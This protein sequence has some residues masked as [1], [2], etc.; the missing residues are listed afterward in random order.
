[1]EQSSL[2]PPEPVALTVAE[3]IDLINNTLAALP[4]R[5][6]QVVG[7]IVEYRVS[8]GKWINFDLK[9]EKADAKIS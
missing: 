3:Y 1:M 2:L 8:Q 6:I 4:S 5:E 7:E 9:D